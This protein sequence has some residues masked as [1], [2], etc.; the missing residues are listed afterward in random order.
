MQLI[1]QASGLLALSQSATPCRRETNREYVKEEERPKRE[2]ADSFQVLRIA[3]NEVEK[4]NHGWFVVR[5]RSTQ[6]ITD[7]VTIEERH[8]RERDFFSD[9][10]PWSELRKDRVGIRTL[11][12]FLGSLLDNH[13]SSE[14]PGVVKDIEQHMSSTL[15]D[16]DLLGPSRQSSADQRRFLMRF[17]NTYQNDVDNALCGNYNPE[18]NATDARKLRMHIR[19]LSD[20]FA[21]CM[22]VSG[23]AK[24]FQTLEDAV[25]SDFGY[26]SGDRSNILD[27]IREAY[28]ESRGAELPGTVNPR[29]L[30]YMFR[31]QSGPWKSIASIYVDRVSCCFGIQ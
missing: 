24:I 14:F 8:I 16:L 21:E 9:H 10:A 31:Q 4:L 20:K 12:L 5:N 6:E 11:R 3:Q 26:F 23:Y 30:E 27:W 29:V 1:P 17:A 13:I 18:H 19:A 28:R 2:V 7:G 25:E 22:A 15:K